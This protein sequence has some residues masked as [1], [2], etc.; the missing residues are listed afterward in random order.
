MKNLCPIQHHTSPTLTL[1][2]DVDLLVRGRTNRHN[3]RAAAT[4]AGQPSRT[5]RPLDTAPFRTPRVGAETPDDVC[6]CLP[7]RRRLGLVL[8]LLVRH[9]VS[10]RWKHR[11]GVHGARW[12]FR[13]SRARLFPGRLSRDAAV[14]RRVR[15]FVLVL[16]LFF[17][18]AR[19]H[20]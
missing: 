5:Q 4:A 3:R 12:F 10:R 15:C 9:A 13:H 18:W 17:C 6:P 20:F 7:G 11:R 14:Q 19:T 1:V 2:L 8:P 16:V